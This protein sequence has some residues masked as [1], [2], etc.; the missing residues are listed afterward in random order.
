MES[1]SRK[2][3]R[4]ALYYKALDADS[5]WH[6]LLV[7]HFGQAAGDKRYTAAGKGEPGSELRQAHDAYMVAINEHIADMRQ[8]NL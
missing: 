6:K 3:P 2:D 1:E 8:R 7:E 5:A 4:Y